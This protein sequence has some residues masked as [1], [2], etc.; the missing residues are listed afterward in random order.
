MESINA[1]VSKTL[2]GITGLVPDIVASCSRSFQKRAAQLGALMTIFPVISAAMAGLCTYIIIGSI[3]VALGLFAVF[4]TIIYFAER[5]IVTGVGGVGL[6]SL[7]FR[8]SLLAATTMLVLYSGHQ[9][10][11]E[12]EIEQFARQ[13]FDSLQQ[14]SIS[15]IDD[16]RSAFLNKV[17]QI[18]I[19]TIDLQA[20]F[21]LE[22]DSLE[23]EEA[24]KLASNA[25]GQGDA[26][27]RRERRYHRRMASYYTPGFQTRRWQIDSIKRKH[28]VPLN[29]EIERL[30]GKTFDPSTLGFVDRHHIITQLANREEGSS[31]R[32]LTIVLI[33]LAGIIDLIVLFF[34]HRMDFSEYEKKTEQ[35]KAMNQLEADL[36][37]T[38]HRLDSDMYHALDAMQRE[39]KLEIER[40]SLGAQVEAKAT[41]RQIEAI[42]DIYQAKASAI[43]RLHRSY[44]VQQER[45]GQDE[46][47][48]LQDAY[49]EALD[50]IDNLDQNI[51]S[52]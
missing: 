35:E 45:L 51:P 18:E 39:M 24:G 30:Q 9:I 43:D 6:P 5:A 16:R 36:A 33:L 46:I 15:I 49:N 25:T 26:Y 1:W 27:D 14:D 17:D 7:L 20:E 34:R 40:K 52:S 47:S 21:Q 3:S 13:Q 41:Q 37:E 2:T 32:Y 19:D 22:H 12:K 23:L 44:F 4:W 11:F 38:K 42:V 29:E 50:R 31:I 10:V 28:I 48:Y 8:I